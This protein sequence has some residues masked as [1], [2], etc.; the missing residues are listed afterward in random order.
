M[1]GV[2]L[3]DKIHSLIKHESAR[4]LSVLIL[5]FVGAFLAFY[6][7][8]SSFSKL[9][10]NVAWVNINRYM[11]DE[12]AFT[13]NLDRSLDLFSQAVNT[14]NEN[15]SA[16]FGLGLALALQGEVTSAI[17]AW[18]KSETDPAILI[19]YGLSARSE[20]DL[21]TALIFFRAAD[22]M[23][24]TT[25]EE[26]HTLAGTICQR[27]FAAQHLL[28][29]S[30]FQYCSDYLANNENNLIVNGSLSSQTLYGWEGEHFFTGKNPAR[31]EIEEPE[32][33]G[34]SAVRLTGQNESNHFGLYQPLALAPGTT[35]R[36][37]G[38]FKLA[39]EEN[40]TARLLYIGWQTEDGTPQG[41]HGE[42]RSKQ[43]AWTEFDK[44]FRVPENIRSTI[45]FYPVVFSGEGTVWFD[46]IQLEL[47]SD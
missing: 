20:G 7:A 46:D 26:G 33:A 43:M 24:S 6:Y 8:V 44:A 17:Y 3:I 45:N 1:N 29:K 14:N 2:Q 36:F 47:V 34:D 41:I 11:R 40:L 23:D 10:S 42:Q 5:L 37:S 19:E 39:G 16:R 18:S 4:Q 25:T 13:D 22:A 32:E 28:S 38:R 9:Q 21:D 35:V 15:L 30:N 31:L 12:S 27:S